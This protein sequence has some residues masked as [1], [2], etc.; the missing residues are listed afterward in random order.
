MLGTLCLREIRAGLTAQA[1]PDP[2]W[3]KSRMTLWGAGLTRGCEHIME[4]SLIRH[5][6]ECWKPD[7]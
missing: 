2:E 6:S 5:S 7:C 1:C 3:I 4:V